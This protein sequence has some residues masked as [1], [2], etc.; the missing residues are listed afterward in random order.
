M[1]WALL[2]FAAAVALIMLGFFAVGADNMNISEKAVY[3]LCVV[4]FLI[5]QGFHFLSWVRKH[6]L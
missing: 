5:A 1:R 6:D 3:W 4:A 2:S